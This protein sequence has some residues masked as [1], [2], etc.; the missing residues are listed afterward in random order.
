M[1]KA[2]ACAIFLCIAFT[3]CDAS[4]GTEHTE[5]IISTTQINSPTENYTLAFDPEMITPLEKISQIE[6]NDIEVPLPYERQYRYIYYQ[7]ES[8]Y[9]LLADWHEANEFLGE[10]E[11]ENPFET[12]ISEMILVTFIKHFQIPREDFEKAVAYQWDYQKRYGVDMTSER[13][14]LPNPDIIYT[15]DNDIINEY[16]RRR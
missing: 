15:F 7:L 12:E 11:K 8:T 14:E 9:Y 2:F 5:I 13:F 6:A 16:Y 4:N 10:Y 1:K 3:S